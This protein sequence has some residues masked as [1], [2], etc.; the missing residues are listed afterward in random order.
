MSAS[1]VLSIVFGL[2]EER[3]IE[4]LSKRKWAIFERVTGQLKHI[5]HRV[6]A[7][8]LADEKK[9]HMKRVGT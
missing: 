3:V 2:A 4:G 1:V 9:E 5:R 7:F 8:S 6:S